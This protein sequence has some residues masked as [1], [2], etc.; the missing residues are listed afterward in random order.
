MTD[1]DVKHSGSPQ[2]GPSIVQ[3]SN[4]L[5]MIDSA[6]LMVSSYADGGNAE[7]G[8]AAITSG[9]ALSQHSPGVGNLAL[10][11]TASITNSKQP[12]PKDALTITKSLLA[13]HLINMAILERK[14]DDNLLSVHIDSY[15][16]HEQLDT[17]QCIAA[18]LD[19]QIKNLEFDIGQCQDML[20]PVT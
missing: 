3:L 16:L 15:V 5:P 17:Q 12:S 19:K 2:V 7:G 1:V 11:N 13:G 20:H 10:T 18:E 14:C 8:I 9:L 6:I 4:I